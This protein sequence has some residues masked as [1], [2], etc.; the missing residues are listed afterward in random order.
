[1]EQE[2]G[3]GDWLAV[4]DAIKVRREEL[5]GM[6]LAELSR[7]SGVAE[8]TFRTMVDRERGAESTLVAAAA[9][10][11]W[12]Y[13]FDYLRNILHG[14][15]QKNERPPEENLEPDESFQEE[16]LQELLQTHLHQVKEDIVEL[17]GVV[18]SMHSKI[19]SIVQVMQDRDNGSGTPA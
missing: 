3:Q 17:R 9:I 1:V 10:L 12:P 5:D 15:P 16:R 14:E 6:S 18:D 13:P 2:K 19:D 8:N 4:L 7:L 11:K